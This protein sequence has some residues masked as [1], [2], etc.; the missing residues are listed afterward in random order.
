[1]IVKEVMSDGKEN[2]FKLKKK[3]TDFI[4]KQYKPHMGT[5]ILFLCCSE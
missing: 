4:I 2:Y 3:G 5:L 1:M